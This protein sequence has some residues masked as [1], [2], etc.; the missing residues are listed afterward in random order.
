[1]L[2]L[3]QFQQCSTYTSSK[4][5][6][7]GSYLGNRWIEAQLCG[8]EDK[9]RLMQAMSSDTASHIS[10]VRG[11]IAEWPGNSLGDGGGSHKDEAEDDEV[12][13]PTRGVTSRVAG[14]WGDG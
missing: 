10:Q 11:Q 6:A 8:A 13:I 7:V 9:S 14:E 3:P 12:R 1:M 4:K 2:P 5:L